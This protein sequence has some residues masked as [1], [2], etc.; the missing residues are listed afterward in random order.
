MNNQA[1][2]KKEYIW[3]YEYDARGLEEWLNEQAKNGWQLKKLN[4][5]SAVFVRR[6]SSSPFRTIFGKE[7]KE[8]AKENYLDKGWEF[9]GIR[10]RVLVFQQIREDAE[11]LL[12]DKEEY[13]DFLKKMKRGQW[14]YL[15]LIPL[16]FLLLIGT[17]LSN[18]MEFFLGTPVWST[19]LLIPLCIV[20]ILQVNFSLSNLKK[21]I[22]IVEGVEQI[23]QALE[24][25]RK[26]NKLY[27]FVIVLSLLFLYCSIFLQS[28]SL[29]YMTNDAT[30]SNVK[31]LPRLS[32]AELGGEES[33]RVKQVGG[34]SN[35][36]VPKHLRILETDKY[37]KTLYLYYVE[38]RFSFVKDL[39][40]EDIVESGFHVMK[41]S[42]DVKVMRKATQDT[43]LIIIHDDTRILYA[44]V[45]NE[46][47]DT[48][49]FAEVLKKNYFD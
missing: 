15:C 13:K 33:L 22:G 49:S 29:S 39:M 28:Q 10:N 1:P 14:I 48:E 2:E 30:T 20:G 17:Y 4:Q 3:L 37:G 7:I 8:S 46:L 38:T 26:N 18:P 19:F 12:E 25:K 47:L 35:F 24:E 41:S 31:D 21:E 34:V 42:D 23:H 6:S 36:L 44:R 27:S 32:V 11:V 16:I 43:S 5:R 40:Y 45:S 9:K